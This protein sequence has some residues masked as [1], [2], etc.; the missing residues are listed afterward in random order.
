MFAEKMS[1]TKHSRFW[2][3]ND[4]SEISIGRYRNNLKME[5]DMLYLLHK[6]EF[7]ERA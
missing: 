3:I 5:N 6:Q 2:V 7:R 1:E 4:N